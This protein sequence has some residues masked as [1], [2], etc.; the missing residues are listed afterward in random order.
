[1]A[2]GKH[3]VRLDAVASIRGLLRE[4]EGGESLEGRKACF[5]EGEHLTVDKA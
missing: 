5:A 4:G 2:A 3:E 1:M